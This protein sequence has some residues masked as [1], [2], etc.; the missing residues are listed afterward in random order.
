MDFRFLEATLVGTSNILNNVYASCPIS[1][2]AGPIGDITPTGVDKMWKN[3]LAACDS[4]VTRENID[5]T[6]KGHKY[7]LKFLSV[8]YHSRRRLIL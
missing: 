7:K 5:G 4:E 3:P 8:S 6:E 1:T 2:S